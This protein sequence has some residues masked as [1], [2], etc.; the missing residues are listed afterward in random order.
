MFNKKGEMTTQQIVVLIILIVSFAILLFFIMKLSFGSETEKEVCHNSVVTRGSAI[1]PTEVTPLDCQRQY[2]CITADKDC[3]ARLTNP[4]KKKVETKD[5]LYEVL[6]IELTDCWWM[7]GEGKVNYVGKDYFENLYCSICSQIAF[8]SSI[9]DLMEGD[10]F[11]KE[12]FYRYMALTNMS[13]S[14]QTYSDYLFGT[15]DLTEISAGTSFGEIN[16]EG[17]QYY[18]FMGITSEVGKL[19]WVGTGA[20][21][22]G[23]LA[24]AIP[25]GGSSLM[26]VAI[27]TTGATVGGIIGGAITQKYVSTL[28]EGDSGNDYLLPTLIEA[29][30]EEFN[31]LNCDYIVT[32]S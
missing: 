13:G 21:I 19:H 5:E 25:T 6:A 4:I 24:M 1:V 9:K 23:A 10:S 28:K 26:A 31:Q 7:F 18:S 22:V 20:L 14:S 8:D 17:T 16:L 11:S 2:I 30:S 3:D 29:G 27:V 32:K 12:D 15:N